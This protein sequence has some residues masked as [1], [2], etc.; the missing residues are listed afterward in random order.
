MSDP[1]PSLTRRKLIALWFIIFALATALD[2]IGG[3][4]WMHE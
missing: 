4:Q 1:S 2:T 3:Y